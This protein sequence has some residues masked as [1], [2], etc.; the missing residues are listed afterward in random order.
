MSIQEYLEISHLSVSGFAQILGISRQHLNNI[1]HGHRN[2][3]K[4]L[5]VVIEDTTGGQI[6]RNELLWPEEFV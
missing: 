6:S 1:I 4:K 2:P 3:S 5:A